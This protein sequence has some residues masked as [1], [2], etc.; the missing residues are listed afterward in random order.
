MNN[1]SVSNQDIAPVGKKCRSVPKRSH[2]CISVGKK[3]SSSGV[4]QSPG[5]ETG[6]VKMS[7]GTI[8][9][10]REGHRKESPDQVNWSLL[11]RARC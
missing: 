10:L 9:L 5:S 1:H 2:C 8:V 3:R 4:K 6:Q 11:R 7:L